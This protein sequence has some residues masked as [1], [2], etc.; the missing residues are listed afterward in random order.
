MSKHIF[1]I[2]H[3]SNISSY[4][5]PLSLFQFRPKC[6]SVNLLVV[7]ITSRKFHCNVFSI[8]GKQK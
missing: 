7:V 5:A 2:F 6:N 8:P 4:P 1:K 3:H